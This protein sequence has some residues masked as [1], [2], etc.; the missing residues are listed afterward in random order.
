LVI[1][2]SVLCAADELDI[3]DANQGFTLHRPSA[4]WEI[5]QIEIPA[6]SRYALKI[7]RTAI[8]PEVSVSVYVADFEGT[9]AFLAMNLTERLLQTN[10]RCS[11][12][13][14]GEERLGERSVPFLSCQY[15]A[16]ETAFRSRQHF[17]VAHGSVYAVQCL[18]EAGQFETHAGDFAEFLRSFTIIPLLDAAAYQNAALLRR[19]ARRCGKEVDWA[20]GWTDAARRAHEEKRLVL[21]VVENYQGFNF[22]KAGP[23]AT[24]MDT[25]L[26]DLVRE[27]FVPLQWDARMDAPFE[28]PAV[29][30]MSPHTFGRGVLFATAEGKIVGEGV[31]LE[32]FY[33][34]RRA[35][36]LLAQ[37][38]E[39]GG[40]PASTD[41][42]ALLRR[43]EHAK[44]WERLKDPQSEPEWRLQAALHR[45]LRR[46]EEALR[47]LDHAGAAPDLVLER[48]IVLMRMGQFKEAEELLQGFVDG[49]RQHER[50]VEGRYWLCN[51]G[52]MR[53]GLR[54]ATGELNELAAGFPDSRWGWRAAAILLGGGL[55]GGV[56]K[57]AWPDRKHL[58]A[59]DQPAPAP[60]N[61]P[62]AARAEQDAI[63]Y[64]VDSQL[65]SGS[66]PSGLSSDLWLTAGEVAITAICADSLIPHC[67]QPRV[68]EAINR[69]VHYVLDA[70]TP[71]RPSSGFDYAIWRQIYSVRFLSQ[72]IEKSVADRPPLVLGVNKLIGEMQRQQRPTG[73]WAYTRGSGRDDRSNGFVTA[74]AVCALVNARDA[75]VEVPAA[76]LEEA[77]RA[78]AT[79]RAP[80]GSL[81][82][83]DFPGRLQ[84]ERETES[85][86]RGPLYSLALLRAGKGS[87]E[88]VVHALDVYLTHRVH[89]RKERGKTLCHTGP[90]GQASYY[91]LFNYAYA[92]EAVQA[93]PAGQR[94][95]YRDALLEDVLFLRT[96]DG[97]FCDN[98]FFGRNYGA[99]MA[100]EA[101]RYLRDE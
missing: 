1:C 53:R 79:L 45:Q 19:L 88:A 30:G 50:L 82:Y 44:A 24:F 93:L 84:S 40:A 76:M 77:L 65:E 59:L 10:P 13:N 64:L 89:V 67:G 18:A 61:A 5:V 85:S 46:G 23:A 28:D 52:I 26:V 97:A 87:S 66:W 71:P 49:N 80:D 72:C 22:P 15:Q 95:P 16:G 78:L 41:A 57:L 98:P 32:P 14:R 17:F 90:E 12:F 70:V 58:A 73:G 51:V 62:E 8:A 33:L 34:Y 60:L 94:A 69:A 7:I 56:E 55:A 38:P 92:A 11:R 68:Q 101:L 100:L 83:Y 6:G 9:D 43:G 54:A 74:A 25:D 2:A 99:G 96:S 48:G 3:S 29:Y 75:G 35:C 42:A 37:N 21:V 39:Y 81:L 86:L 20:N 91:L 63:N 47:A 31:S 27:R 36:E 4:Q